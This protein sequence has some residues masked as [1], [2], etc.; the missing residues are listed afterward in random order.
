MITNSGVKKEITIDSIKE[1]II[2]N[3]NDMDLGKKV[4]ELIISMKKKINDSN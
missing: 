4:R 1:L 3:P 2:K